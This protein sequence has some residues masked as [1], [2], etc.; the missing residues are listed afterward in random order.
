MSIEGKYKKLNQ[1]YA[2]RGTDTEN[3]DDADL[4]T[5]PNAMLI[6]G[7]LVQALDNSSYENI[8]PGNGL[9]LTQTP[10]GKA[11]DLD[12]AVHSCK[13]ALNGEWRNLAP[14]ER[15]RLLQN[16]ATLMR[17][18]ANQL[19]RVE[20]LDTGKP[21]REAR[22]SVERSADYFDYYGGAVDK[23]HGE[24]IPLPNGK[25][26][27]TLLEPI[28]VTG[29]I[30]PW[31]VPISMAARG[32]APA[33]ACGNTAV[34][35]P[36]EEAPMSAVLLA[37]LMIEAGLP[38]GVCNVVTGVGAE[39]GIA[40]TQH[41]GVAHITFTGSVETGKAV[42]ASA[43]GHVAS[44][45]LELGGKSPLVIMSDA[46]LDIVIA[47]ISRAI[48]NN[49]GQICSAATR[50]IVSGSIH[51][52]LVSRLAELA[53]GLKIGY[54]LDNPDQGSLISLQHRDSVHAHVE[55]ARARGLDIICGGKPVEVEGYAGGAYYAPTLVD[56]ISNQDNLSQLE[57]FGPVAGIQIVDSLEQA[58]EMSNQTAFGLAA[59]IHTRDINA[60]M[61]F[62]RE[63]RA[64][65]VFI[66][67]YHY[68][69]DTVP[70]GGFGDSGLGREKGFAALANYCETKA[71]TITVRA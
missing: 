30:V 32:L 3:T 34:V 8:D 56:N 36:A 70:F 22:V 45:V 69:G 33:L 40:L 28:G 17:K 5:C 4:A 66:N 37:E 63:V 46:D 12:A 6:D 48:F 31:N 18:R 68:A 55:A 52:E 43:A 38:A 9:V 44:V 10:N 24:T 29:H 20:S 35:K 7:K 15:G 59:G 64:G 65:Q 57:I 41:P 61:R 25:I 53:N 1:F 21:L 42:M 39:V 60:A 26:C 58:I 19:A 54:G 62:S 71:V 47:D 14:K 50:L 23:H 49:A 27:F 13:Q 2:G 11:A 16:I 51:D 67:E